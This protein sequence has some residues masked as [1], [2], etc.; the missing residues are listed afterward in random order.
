M[1][2]PGP[3][4]L[5]AF[6]HPFPSV[7]GLERPEVQGETFG[8]LWPVVVKV[9]AWRTGDRHDAFLP[10]PPAL[11]SLHSVTFDVSGHQNWAF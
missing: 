10:S 7:H 2:V 5:V 3:D 9:H 6:R 11:F 4:K 1:T 8:A